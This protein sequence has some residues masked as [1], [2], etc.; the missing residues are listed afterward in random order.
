MSICD[1]HYS[2]H[3]DISDSIYN[4]HKM[5]NYIQLYYYLYIKSNYTVYLH[6]V[7]LWLSVN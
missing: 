5:H 2:Y 3:T 1:L 6:N 7:Y 4:I